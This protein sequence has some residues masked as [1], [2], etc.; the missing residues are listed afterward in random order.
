MSDTI[1]NQL[2]VDASVAGEKIAQGYMDKIYIKQG[3]TIDRSKACPAFD[4]QLTKGLKTHKVEEKFR[5]D[6]FGDFGVEIFQCIIKPQLGWYYHVDAEYIN[7]VICDQW[8]PRYGY[9]VRWAKF[10]EWMVDHLAHNKS[11]RC[12]YRRLA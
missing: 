7:Y 5:Q 11:R 6:D 2:E 4:C 12:S 8:E 10:K 9:W 3:F 1:R